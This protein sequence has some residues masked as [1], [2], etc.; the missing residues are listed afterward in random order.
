MNHFSLSASELCS[1]ALEGTTNTRSTD[2]SISKPSLS[3]TQHQ[4]GLLGQN[5]CESGKLP[6]RCRGASLTK[7]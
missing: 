4:R 7:R 2:T 5:L 6:S 1:V 3:G